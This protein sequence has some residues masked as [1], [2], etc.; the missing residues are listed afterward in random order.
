MPLL[1]PGVTAAH[2]AGIKWQSGRAKPIDT[3]RLGLPDI[4]PRITL[5]IPTTRVRESSGRCGGKTFSKDLP[6]SALGAYTHSE[7]RPPLLTV[8][9]FSI[10][11][12]LA[13]L[14]HVLRIGCALSARKLLYF[15]V[16]REIGWA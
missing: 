12:L 7:G 14:A 2:G 13:M 6:R 9:R 10:N 5:V 16:S 11:D 3:A 4:S 8:K 1:G 15:R